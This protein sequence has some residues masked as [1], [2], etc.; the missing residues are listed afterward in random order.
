MFWEG[1]RLCEVI[2]RGR[3]TVHVI[4]GI[5]FSGEAEIFAQY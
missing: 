3:S 5:G 4:A 2:A 1:G